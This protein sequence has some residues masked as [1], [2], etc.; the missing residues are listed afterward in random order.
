[1]PNHIWKEMI[2]HPPVWDDV[3]IIN[4]EEYCKIRCLKKSRAYVNA[5]VEQTKYR[6]EFKM[7]R[8]EKIIAI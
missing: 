6:N 2:N 5:T 7:K 4:W 8:L 1:M 3:K